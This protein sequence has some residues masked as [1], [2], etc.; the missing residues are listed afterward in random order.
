MSEN[1]SK[2]F[3]DL[4]RSQGKEME[5]LLDPEGS[6]FIARFIGSDGQEHVLRELKSKE[7]YDSWYERVGRNI[8]KKDAELGN[9]GK[10]RMDFGPSELNQGKEVPRSEKNPAD[11][12]KFEDLIKNILTEKDLGKEGYVFVCKGKE[13]GEKEFR[14]LVEFDTADEARDWYDSYGIWIMEDDGEVKVEYGPAE[15]KK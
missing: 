2:K 15:L 13:R 1:I 10:I 7:E 4:M 8:E 12:K 3:E 9:Y 6:V 5:K 11:T 14:P